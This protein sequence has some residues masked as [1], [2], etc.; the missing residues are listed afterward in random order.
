MTRKG[1]ETW[2]KITV[3]WKNDLV[4][5]NGF[6]RNI[7][8]I[9]GIFVS[10]CF[11]KCSDSCV[12]LSFFFFFRKKD[13]LCRE[14]VVLRPRIMVFKAG[15]PVPP[16]SPR[17]YLGMPM[18]NHNFSHILWDPNASKLVNSEAYVIFIFS[19]FICFFPLWPKPCDHVAY[20]GN[21]IPPSYIS[22]L[23]LWLYI[24]N[25]PLQGCRKMNQPVIFVNITSGF[26]RF[27]SP[28]LQWFSWSQ[29]C[30]FQASSAAAGS[31]FSQWKDVLKIDPR[32]LHAGIRIDL[33]NP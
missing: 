27:C 7:P 11:H 17:F 23:G 19:F 3:P 9:C 8:Q 5:E 20:I 13:G 15:Q 21:D 29:N 31:R 30:W 26:C 33:N 6:Q 16:R 24:T 2:S 28:H 14:T 10:C 32:G 18:V 12:S 1:V 4:N 25:K 22:I